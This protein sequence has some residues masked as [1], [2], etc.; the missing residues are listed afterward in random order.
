[1]PS[2]SLLLPA[3]KLHNACMSIICRQ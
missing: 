2:F 1:M 3:K